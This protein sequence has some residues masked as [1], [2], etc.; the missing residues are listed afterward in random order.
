MTTSTP[1]GGS[2]LGPKPP[3]DDRFHALMGIVVG[4]AA[5]AMLWLV[6]IQV[7]RKLT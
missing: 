5:G 6:L 7:I 2:G 1:A 3:R 4:I